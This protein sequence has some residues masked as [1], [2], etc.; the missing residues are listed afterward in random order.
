[1]SAIVTVVRT[2]LQALA[3]P[4]DATAMRAYLRDQFAFMG[5]KSPARRSACRTVAAPLVN[6]VLK[7]KGIP[8]KD[9]KQVHISHFTC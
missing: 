5:V 8:A 2:A 6:A 3:K 9:K 1:M 7:N 4:K